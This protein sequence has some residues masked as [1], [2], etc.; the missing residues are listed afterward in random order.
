MPAEGRALFDVPISFGPKS[1]TTPADAQVH[2]CTLSNETLFPKESVMFSH[3][4]AYSAILRSLLLASRIILSELQTFNLFIARKCHE[5]FIEHE[6]IIALQ[7]DILVSK[8]R[9]YL[10]D[11]DLDPDMSDRGEE[12]G[13]TRLRPNEERDLIIVDYALIKAVMDKE[14][15]KRRN[16]A[17]AYIA[18]KF[19][20]KWPT[21]WSSGL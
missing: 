9:N 20:T 19:F 14:S 1:F 21:Y 13:M 10:P 6:D 3:R 5:G 7:P 11:I 17:L 2:I 4:K 12:Y 15:G 18:I 8:I 16:I